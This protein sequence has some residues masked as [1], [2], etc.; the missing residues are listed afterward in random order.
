MLVVVFAQIKI[1]VNEAGNPGGPVNVVIS[2]GENSGIVA[3]KLTENGVISKPWL[4]KMAARFK[5]LDKHLKAG[6]YQFVKGISL[7]EVI[8]QIAQGDVF[9]RKITLPEGLT[10][11]QMLE[12]IKEE[13]ALSGKVTIIPQEGE[14]L[15]ETYSFVLGE[16]KDSVIMQAME[17]MQKVKKQAWENRDEGL[18]LK[19]VDEMMILASIIEKETA[20]PAERRL[21]AS[22]FVN[23][24]RKGM[25][26]Q[27]DPT[28]I[29]ALTKGK[30]ELERKLTRK[31]LEIDSPYNTYKYYGLPPKPICNPGKASIEAAVH[32]EMS[33]YLYF[34]ANGSGGH[35]FALSLKEHNNN[36]KNWK[37]VQQQ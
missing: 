14:M 35:S 37:K 21:V 13:E 29:Y 18:P 33:D 28:V 26:L 36:V 32:P 10:A 12:I 16:T 4:F 31:D 30:K 17:A 25:R 9:F 15:P 11:K 3:Q 5:G 23:R 1:W 19:N 6:E 7:S 2:K 22:V 20:I 8:R 24:L 34:V 27:T